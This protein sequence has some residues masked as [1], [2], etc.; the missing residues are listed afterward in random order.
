MFTDVQCRQWPATRSSLFF[1]QLLHFPCQTSTTLLYFLFARF[2]F[3]NRFDSKSMRRLCMLVKVTLLR[4][5]VRSARQSNK[6][7]SSLNFRSTFELLSPCSPLFLS[8]SLYIH[9]YAGRL[10]FVKL[11]AY[12]F[13]LPQ[14][15]FYSIPMR[16]R[17]APFNAQPSSRTSFCCL[18]NCTCDAEHVLLTKA[19]Y[20]LKKA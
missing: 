5:F 4:S 19:F 10:C 8:F 3:S 17:T 16:L 18:V 14:F 12:L 2:C 13:S 15:N 11:A 6:N 9:K 20:F 7:A 1:P